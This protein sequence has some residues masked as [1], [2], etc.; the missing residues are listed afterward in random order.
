MGDLSR[1]TGRDSVEEARLVEQRKKFYSAY[2]SQSIDMLQKVAAKQIES[3][4]RNDK[5]IQQYDSANAAAVKEILPKIV[6]NQ[7]EH[8]Q[9]TFSDYDTNTDNNKFLKEYIEGRAASEGVEIPKGMKITVG[10]YNTEKAREIYSGNPMKAIPGIQT[11]QYWNEAPI[12]TAEFLGVEDSYR[13]FVDWLNNHQDLFKLDKDYKSAEQYCDEKG[14][15]S[16]QKEK[17]LELYRFHNV[18]VNVFGARIKDMFNFF[19]QDKETVSAKIENMKIS[20]E[21]KE[22]MRKVKEFVD[23]YY[24]VEVE[25][26]GKT[27]NLLSLSHEDKEEIKKVS[28]EFLKFA[29]KIQP[30]LKKHALYFAQKEVQGEE[31]SDAGATSRWTAYGLMGLLGYGIYKGYAEG[32]DM[33][34]GIK[35]SAKFAEFIKKNPQK[36]NDILNKCVA[37]FDKLNKNGTVYN[38]EGAL[39]GTKLMERYMKRIGFEGGEYLVYQKS[40]QN[41]GIKAWINPITKFTN[42]RGKALTALLGATFLLSGDD[43]AG[44]VK[45]FFQDQNNFGTS[46]AAGFAIAGAAGGVLSSA[47]FVPTFQGVVDFVRADKTLTKMGVSPK[48]PMVNKIFSKKTVEFLSKIPLAKKLAVPALFGGLGVVLASTSSGSSWTSMALTRWLMGKNGDELEQ[49]NIIDKKDN[50]FTSANENMME[51]EA[52]KGKW[53]GITGIPLNTSPTG[54]WTIGSVCG[55][56]GAFTHSNPVIQNTFTTLQGCSETVTASAWQIAGNAVRNAELNRQK[57]ELV[58]SAKKDN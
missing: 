12:K 8:S 44:A 49:K 39:K 3:S 11:E 41:R 18:R 38:E 9:K 47:A 16:S 54:D 1:I 29:E 46:T 13:E 21:Q 57:Q 37:K 56:M 28:P 36:G 27:Y 45:D 43:C 26:G 58:E 50:T 7:S 2:A 24:K 31:L 52:Y 51:Y 14:L 15:N 20:D 32:K 22:E 10:S 5:Q 53:Q 34:E 33:K 19:S 30:E 48:S 40:I 25:Y 35:K 42:T 23:K 4:E 6:A 17:V 55:T